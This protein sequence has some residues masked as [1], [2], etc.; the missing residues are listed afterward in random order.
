MQV[1]AL[2]AADDRVVHAGRAVDQVQ[3]GVE[4]LSARRILVGCGRSSVIQPVSTLVIR[5]PSLSSIS[6][7]LV[8]VSM[9]SAAFAMLVCGWPAPL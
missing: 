1:L 4:A 6:R 9:L 3:R 7:A 2:L 5:M 8:R